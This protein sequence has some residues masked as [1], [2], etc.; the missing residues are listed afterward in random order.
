MFYIYSDFDYEIDQ[1]TQ[2]EEIIRVGDLKR[3]LLLFFFAKIT[4]YIM[5]R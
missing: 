2:K 5:E 4:L 3:G 1:K